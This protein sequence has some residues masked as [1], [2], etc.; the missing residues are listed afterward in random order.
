M[1]GRETK[2]LAIAK[3]KFPFA[4]SYKMYLKGCRFLPKMKGYAYLEVSYVMLNLPTP[5][6]LLSINILLS[7]SIASLI[8]QLSQLPFSACIAKILQAN[9]GVDIKQNRLRVKPETSC[10][11]WR[12]K[13]P[14]FTTIIRW[15]GL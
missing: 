8:S 5:T 3:L 13:T 14:V 15:S 1:S 7:K 12:L 6:W 9:P 2:S 4:P 10:E 11:E